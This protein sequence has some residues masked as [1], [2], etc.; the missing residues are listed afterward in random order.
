MADPREMAEQAFMLMQEALQ[1]SEA[2]VAELSERVS[3]HDAPASELAVQ[4]DALTQRLES[5][6][7]ERDRL[8]REAGQLEEMIGAEQARVEQLKKKLEVAE[9]GPDKLTKKE[10]NFWRGKAEDFDRLTREHRDRTAQLR[11]ELDARGAELERR[12]AECE[13]LGRELEEA[14]AAGERLEDVVKERDSRLAELSALLEKTRAELDKSHEHVERNR[15]EREE[16]ATEIDALRAELHAQSV[17]AQERMAEAEIHAADLRERLAALE[18]ELHDERECS[19]NLNELA[20]ERRETLHTLEDRLEEAEER[21]EEAKWRLAQAQHFERLVR[22]RKTLIRALIARIREKSK[23]NVALKAGLDG[24]RTYKAAAEAK[25]HKLLARIDSLRA[26]LK[27]YEETI[28][29]QQAAAQAKQQ[30]ALAEAA[31]EADARATETEARRAEAEA[32]VADLEMRLNSQ[33]EIV[34]SLEDELKAARAVK[35]DDAERADELDRLNGTLERL[36]AE[37]EAKTQVVLQL[38][39]DADD[40]Q[41]KLAKARSSESETARLKTLADKSQ[42]TLDTLRRENEQLRAMLRAYSQSAPSYSNVAE[43]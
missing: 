27:E 10:I 18:T 16:A 8:K 38:Q 1:N 13:R 22:R 15:R 26:K 14:R 12:A 43:K 2:R 3:R 42:G 25:H 9:S 40:Q 33:A 34:Q 24:L 28:A 36:K 31:A 35:H 21:Y 7:A 20:N 30:A 4:I 23:A 5:V 41:R 11:T 32:R 39:K 37:L 17:R 6:A 29:Q 19:A